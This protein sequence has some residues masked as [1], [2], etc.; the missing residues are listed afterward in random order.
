MGYP[1]RS[2]AGEKPVTSSLQLRQTLKRSEKCTMPKFCIGQC[3][4]F[5]FKKM[6]FMLICNSVLIPNIVKY[7]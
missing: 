6:L 7:Q 4:N 5:S 2:N 1:N 3:S